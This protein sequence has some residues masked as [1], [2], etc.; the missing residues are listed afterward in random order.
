MFICTISILN[1]FGKQRLDAVLAPIGFTWREMVVLMVLRHQPGASQTTLSQY[2]QTDKANVTKLLRQMEEKGL[3]R[4]SA[5]RQDSRRNQLLLTRRGQQALPQ[6]DAAMARW[7]QDCF[8]G[9]SAAE[10]AQWRRLTALI[11]ANLLP[12]PNPVPTEKK[13]EMT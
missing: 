7:E 1:K 13:G 12:Q 8:T 9:L 10:A 2:L 3:L 5:D 6:L 4:R 11:I